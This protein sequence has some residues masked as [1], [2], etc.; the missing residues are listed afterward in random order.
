MKGKKYGG[1]QKGT[2]NKTT[3]M[4]KKIIAE[5]LDNYSASGLMASDFEKLLAKDRLYIAK[6]L[7]QYVMPKMQAVAVDMDADVKTRTTEDKL[8][9]LSKLPE[10]GTD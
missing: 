5:L 10:Q 6:D 3:S 9:E 2:P 1:R 4:S 7:M 8:L